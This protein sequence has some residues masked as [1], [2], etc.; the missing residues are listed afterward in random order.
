M[1]VFNMRNANDLTKL[2]KSARQCTSRYLIYTITPFY[3]FTLIATPT[4]AF[5]F[6]KIIC[7]VLCNWDSIA[8]LSQ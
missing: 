1:F 2:P 7:A 6:D 3:C 4:A 8:D 5:N